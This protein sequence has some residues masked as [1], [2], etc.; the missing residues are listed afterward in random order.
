MTSATSEVLK[1]HQKLLA[2]GTDRTAI[3]SLGVACG[4]GFFEAT[5]NPPAKKQRVRSP[6]WP[7]SVHRSVATQIGASNGNLPGRRKHP[8]IKVRIPKMSFVKN[9]PLFVGP[10]SAPS[11]W[12]PSPF[13]ASTVLCWRDDGG[14]ES[15]ESTVSDLACRA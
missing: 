10:R 5:K 11:L 12:D 1:I 2:F 15:L 3:A 14:G 9:S 8:V 4:M 7:R 13:R 6:P